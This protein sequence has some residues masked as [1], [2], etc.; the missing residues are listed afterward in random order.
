MKVDGYLDRVLFF[1][2]ARIRAFFS[3]FYLS[4]FGVRVCGIKSFGSIA[5]LDGCPHTHDSNIPE[6]NLMHT[7]DSK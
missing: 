1:R 2:A 5:K 7:T 4:V 3:H 6:G